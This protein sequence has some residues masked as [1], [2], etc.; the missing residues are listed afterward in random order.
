MSKRVVWLLWAPLH[1][2][3]S[4]LKCVSLQSVP[5]CNPQGSRS[6]KNHC[7]IT[8]CNLKIFVQG[9]GGT[10]EVPSKNLINH[11]CSILNFQVV[12]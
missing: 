1:E 7:F 3:A 4:L 8:V 9:E 11:W 6:T 2:W 12:L 10:T 5:N